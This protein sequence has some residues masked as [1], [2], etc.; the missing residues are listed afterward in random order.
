MSHQ[1][2][3]GTGNCR[4]L[5]ESST[6]HWHFQHQPGM[7]AHRRW[8]KQGEHGTGQRGCITLLLPTSAWGSCR[9]PL[10]GLQA[11][12]KRCSPQKPPHSLQVHQPA[13]LESK[14]PQTGMDLHQGL[15]QRALPAAAAGGKGQSSLPILAKGPWAS[16]APWY[17][18]SLPH[19]ADPITTTPVFSSQLFHNSCNNL[20]KEIS[21]LGIKYSWA[22]TLQGNTAFLGVRPSSRG[23]H[24]FAFAGVIMFLIDWMLQ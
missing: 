9:T 16:K 10:K 19:G 2:E 3:T 21:S 11:S 5:D 24:G 22:H 23:W 6:K 20:L 12:T 1:G 17:Q 8:G 7:R 13:L 14:M 15:L 4:M 18:G